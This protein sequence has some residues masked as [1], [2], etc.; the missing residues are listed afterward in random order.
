MDSDRKDEGYGNLVYIF[1]IPFILLIIL[2]SWVGLK[3]AQAG[4]S[5]RAVQFATF[6]AWFIA[7][8]FI[9]ATTV[10][11][12]T[13]LLSLMTGNNTLFSYT[14][15]HLGDLVLWPVWGRILS[16]FF[17]MGL[18]D[19]SLSTPFMLIVIFQLILFLLIGYRLARHLPVT[20]ID[21]ATAI[22][23]RKCGTDPYELRIIR[24]QTDSGYAKACNHYRDSGNPP[25]LAF[26]TLSM[27][28]IWP[29]DVYRFN[30]H[31]RS[32]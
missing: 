20:L 26:F 18:T 17:R 14:F 16:F 28:G 23:A 19:F 27:A 21:V 1:L 11:P 5:Y 4:Y 3:T 24:M 31:R 9:G 25:L 30:L 12:L 7:S 2:F 10:I 13:F 22:R 8:N 32:I 15:Q 29:N 6:P